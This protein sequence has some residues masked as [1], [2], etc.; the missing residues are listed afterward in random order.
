VPH[1]QLR[2]NP[3]L[4][5]PL[6]TPFI[7]LGVRGTGR[8]KGKGNDILQSPKTASSVRRN[9]NSFRQSGKVLPLTSGKL[10]TPI[11]CSTSSPAGKWL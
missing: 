9:S 6:V 4:V 3:Q 2:G 8:F 10:R 11:I 1:I 7:L 5:I